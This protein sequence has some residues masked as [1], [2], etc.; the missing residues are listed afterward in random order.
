VSLSEQGMCSSV[1][2]LG[3]WYRSEANGGGGESDLEVRII[4]TRF[5]IQI[6][7]S[8]TQC[9]NVHSVANETRFE[10]TAL[11]IYVTGREVG[12]LNKDTVA[13]DLEHNIPESESIF[14]SNLSPYC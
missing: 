8:E 3:E 12:F 10:M 6:P 1:G 2:R 4:S 7:K 5:S 13:L 14:F 11:P 9:D